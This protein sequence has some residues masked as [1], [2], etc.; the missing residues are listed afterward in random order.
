MGRITIP[1]E[2]LALNQT[3]AQVI[4]I[5]RTAPGISTPRLQLR[6]GM[7]WGILNYHVRRLVEAGLVRR[8][9][10]G[11]RSYLALTARCEPE[12]G[13]ACLASDAARR[14]AMAVIS[15]PG[16]NPRTIAERASI[17]IRMTYYHLAALRG[18]GLLVD[19]P[20]GTAPYPGPGLLKLIGELTRNGHAPSEAGSRP[21]ARV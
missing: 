18:A 3:R 7:K 5:L 2:R 8:V 12:T 15:A 11:R 4:E 16:A 1:V 20:H 6:M 10:L 14:V 13:D 21:A 9:K 19:S 17:S